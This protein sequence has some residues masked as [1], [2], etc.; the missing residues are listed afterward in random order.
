[1]IHLIEKQTNPVTLVG[2]DPCEDLLC[3]AGMSSSEA[4]PALV[5]WR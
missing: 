2:N 5:D 1:M 3:L 4:E